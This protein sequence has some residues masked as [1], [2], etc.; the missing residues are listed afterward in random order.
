MKNETIKRYIFMT[1]GMFIAGASIK[2]ILIPTGISTGGVSGLS[3]ILQQMTNIPYNVFNLSINLLLLVLAAFMLD[4]EILYKAIYGSI[5]FPLI[6]GFLPEW[7]LA[8]TD[9]LLAMIAGGAISGIGFSIIFLNGGSTGG[10]SLPPY[11]FRKYFGM[12]LTT[13]FFLADALSI[14]AN[15][16]L[17]EVKFVLYGTISV[18]ILKI[19]ADYIETGI[20]R[21]KAVYIIS[22]YMDEMTN[23]IHNEL[24]RGTT[25]IQAISGYL[26]K[27]RPIILTIVANSELNKLREKAEAIDPDVFMMVSSVAEVRGRGFSTEK[28]KVNK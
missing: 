16:L 11:I 12:P 26:R 17:G 24:N 5:M 8:G 9:T 3:V 20:T 1:I 6:I 13:G 19:T 14:G 28:I 2:F 27:D 25:D 18:I 15:L 21:R 23:Y 10:T 22:E 7:N 4:K